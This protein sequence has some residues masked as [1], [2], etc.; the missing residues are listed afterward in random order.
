MIRPSDEGTER[1]RAFAER[2]L[3]REEFEA[4]V[5]AP[6][7]DAERAATLELVD[8]FCRRYPTPAA[9]PAYVRRAYR[10]RLSGLW[11]QKPWPDRKAYCEC[12]PLIPPRGFIHFR[13]GSKSFGPSNRAGLP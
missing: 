10:S 7:S 5:G 4:Y 8:W 12:L 11:R 1:L 6:I 13:D 3:T 2:R 9:R